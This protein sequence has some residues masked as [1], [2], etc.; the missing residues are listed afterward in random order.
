M[1]EAGISVALVLKLEVALFLIVSHICLYYFLKQFWNQSLNF[2]LKTVGIYIF[3][4]VLV[5]YS[6]NGQFD[7]IAFLFALFSIIMFLDKRYDVFLL[8]VA[9]SATFKYQTAIFLFPLLIVSLLR[10]FNN[11]PISKT[12]KNRYI[13][14]AFSL[15]AVNLF[16]AILSMPYLT[17]TR[18]DLIMNGVNAFSPHGQISWEL[19]VFIVLLFVSVTLFVGIRLMDKSRLISLFAVFSLLPCLTMPYFQPWYMPLFFIYLLIPQNKHCLK[20]TIV[21]IIFVAIVLSFGGLSYNPLFI[22]DR[23]RGLLTFPSLNFFA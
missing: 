17:N 5:L 16:T 15:F 18:P 14:A 10:I 19:Q 21:W 4:V 3:Y 12:I 20:I 9:V 11:F 23:I 6:A 8:F 2:A 1:L 13:I 7:A 22:L